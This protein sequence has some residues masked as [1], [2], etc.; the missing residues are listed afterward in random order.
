M[1]KV[2][3][4]TSTLPN[5]QKQIFQEKMA[6]KGQKYPPQPTI[7]FQ[8]YQPPKPKSTHQFDTNSIMPIYPQGFPYGNPYG[9]DTH[10]MMPPII[11]NI[12]INTDG[13]TGHHGRLFII[14]E[15]ALPEK[16][17]ITS[18]TTLGE[19]INMYQFIRSSIFNN[20]DGTDI[21]LDGKSSNSLLSFI[22]FGDLNPYNTYKFSNNPYKGLPDGFLLYR[23]CYPIRH[24]ESSGGVMCA[25]DSTGVN[26]RIYKLLEG[27]FLA[28]RLSP[29]KFFEFDEWREIFFY[30]FVREQIIKKKVC[31]HFITL[32]GY[33]ISEKAGI[34]FDKI[35][36]LKDNTKQI[37][38]EPQ[39][40]NIPL[41]QENEYIPI[42]E[43]KTQNMNRNEKV[44]DIN[45]NAYLGKTLVMLTESPTYNILGWASKTY[46][47]KGNIKE[48]INRGVHTEK[49]W[50]NILF[51]LM[52]SLYT[53]Q[54]NNIFISNFRL[55]NNVF[56]KD[57][58]LRGPITNYWKY[59]IDNIEYYLPNLGY[60][61]LIDTNYKDLN[62]ETTNI[63]KKNVTITHKL[64]GKFLDNTVTNEIMKNNVFD[65]FKNVFNVNEF[66][67]DFINSGGCKPPSEIINLLGN[68]YADAANDIDKDIKKYILKYMTPFLH[69][70]IGTYLKDSEIPNIRR[71]D[72][73]EFTKGQ[74][75]VYVDS[76]GSF[77]F[78]IFIETING[79]S[80]ILTKD[81]N[82]NSYIIEISIPVSSLFNYSK[83]EQIMQIFKPN[84]SNMN[85]DELLET[86]II[87]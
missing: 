11:K 78:V 66:K 9:Y 80:K 77:K 68:I 53:M 63:I 44:M 59:N 56:I 1:Y 39:Y 65:M 46:Q 38:K 57:L 33:F 18:A 37:H 36:I 4:N 12:Q 15:D 64:D 40:I 27:V 23:T 35:S 61:V 32:Y 19:R 17:I 28:Y 26:V 24:Q 50:L 16:T 71:D 60:L 14:N 74:I 84:E 81:D 21:G 31:P 7:N 85:E 22:K 10:M 41:N 70:R 86:Y 87:R 51:Q 62:S 72:M 49:E 47:L 6:E 34:D 75:L 83:S 55:E 5:E 30:E 76:Y 48:M 42:T 58:S 79:N 45:P 67:Q 3:D 20:V 8:Y 69:N 73:R 2:P 52:I 25:K 82:Q 13:P 43:K 29:T 54:L